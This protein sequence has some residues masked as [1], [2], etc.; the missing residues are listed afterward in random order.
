MLDIQMYSVFTRQYRDVIPEMGWHSG[1]LSRGT[2][3][4]KHP[5][6]KVLEVNRSKNPKL[7]SQR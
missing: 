7:A 1:R 2:A 5:A 3:S 4:I 6:H